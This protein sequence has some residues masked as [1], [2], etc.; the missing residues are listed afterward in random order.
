[1]KSEFIF[2]DKEKKIIHAYKWT[3]ENNMKPKAIVQIA[4]GMA[5][6]MARYDYF[7][8]KL[9]EAGYCVYGNDHRGHGN[10]AATKEELGFLADKDGFNLMVDDLYEL[11]QIIKKENKGIPVILLGHSMGSFLVQRYIQIHGDE[12]K[13]VFLSGSNGIPPIGTSMG[14]I[15]AKVERIIR[16][17]NHKSRLMDK[18]LFSSYNKRVKT[19]VTEFDW[20]ST[21]EKEVDK[22]IKDPLCGFICSTSFYYELLKGVKHNFKSERLSAI[23]KDLKIHI[24][25]GEEDPVGNYGKGVIQ[26]Y[27]IYHNL[28]VE[29]VTYKLYKGGR[30]EILNEVNKDEVIKDILTKMQEFL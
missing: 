7:A 10:T 28:G 21:D 5:E 8:Q 13:G 29:K 22:Y 27:T 11:T 25:S 4:H 24:M 2:A 6:T 20:L 23:P 19:N 14:I 26:L 15:I 1:M 12:L 18:L 9:N 16:G 3:L 17:K 30:H